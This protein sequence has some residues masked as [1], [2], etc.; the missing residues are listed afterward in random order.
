MTTA[1]PAELDAMRRAVELSRAA[2]GTT[3]P[4]PP[5][6]AVVLDADGVVAGEGWTRPPGGPHAEVVALQSAGP[7]A[8]GGTAVVTLEP[9][10]HTGRTGP[11]TRALLD[12]G[13]ARVVVACADRT[14]E[15]AGGADALRAA[16][17]DVVP[18]V[19]ADE[20]AHGPL[21]AWLT[22]RR[23]GR[24]FVTWKFAATLDGRSAAADGTSRWITGGTARAD[25]HRLRAEAD[26]VVAGVGTVLADDPL[27]TTRP[28]PGHQ[29]LRV[30]VDST[31]RTPLTARALS[32]ERPAVVA[33]RDDVPPGTYPDQ[34]P[35][36]GDDRGRV[37]LLALLQALADRE[38]VSVLLEG[39][40]TLAGAF[41]E[42]GLVDRVVGYVA[43]AL[44]GAGPA[45]L[46]DAGAGTISE[47]HRLRLDDVARTGDDVRLTLRP[48]NGGA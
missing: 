6:G 14:A 19:L 20:V 39:G 32:G 21:E 7:R 22:S 43:P 9:C 3:S 42:R 30:V 26:A 5:V 33:V 10:R 41:V 12:A 44:L 38:V 46:A 35:L 2:L 36:P 37:D 13:V 8:R 16:G 31:G 23:T 1:R 45:A 15:A 40:P 27:L 18:D 25:V 24:P 11:C 34:L 17:V 4:N 29:P 47:I 48:R 28:D